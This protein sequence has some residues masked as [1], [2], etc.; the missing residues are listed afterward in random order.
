SPD[1]AQMGMI[2]L[3]AVVV[4]A[5]DMHQRQAQIVDEPLT[6]EEAST[7]FEYCPGTWTEQDEK[8][9]QKLEAKFFAQHHLA[10]W[11]KQT[12]MPDEVLHDWEVKCEIARS[13]LEEALN[14]R[15]LIG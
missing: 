4:L 1:F 10:Y 8:A 9:L 12:G 15:G 3:T 5:V 7:D 6:E 14:R 11:A 13:E 2:V